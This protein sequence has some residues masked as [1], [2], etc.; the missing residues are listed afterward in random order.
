MIADPISAI[1]NTRSFHGQ[2]LAELG[3][4]SRWIYDIAKP[5][6]T[7]KILQLGARS[8]EITSY[9]LANQTRLRISDPDS[10]YCTKLNEKYKN[11]PN[12]ISLHRINPENTRFSHSYSA[13]LKQ[14]DTVLFLNLVNSITD[15][16]IALSNI[17]K[18]AKNNGTLALLSRAHTALYKNLDQ[19]FEDWRRTNCRYVQSQLGGK[20][21]HVKSNFFS[22]LSLENSPEPDQNSI[23]RREVPSFSTKQDPSFSEPGIFMISI[24]NKI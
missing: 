16:R 9:F 5:Y 14:F 7:G 21:K 23:Y 2:P 24:L 22:L 20:F 11:D 1:Q 13:Y 18:L 6:V 4:V 12:V 15:N 19:G 17:V 3:S 8:G 10:D